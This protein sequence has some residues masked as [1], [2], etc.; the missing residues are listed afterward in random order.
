MVIGMLLMAAPAAY[1][2][3]QTSRTWV[4][5]VGNDSDPCSRTAPCK[6]FAGAISKTAI[7]GEINCLDPGGF[8]AVNITKSITIDCH[9][10]FAG[11]LSQ[12]FVAAISI[13]LVL[14]TTAD[15]LQTVRLRNLIV[16]GNGETTCGGVTCGTRFGTR[17]IDILS[18]AQVFLDDMLIYNFSAEGVRDRRTSPVGS[19]LHIRNSQIR[20]NG[21]TGIALVAN[22]GVNAIIDNSQMDFN[23][24]G[25]AVGANNNAMVFRS[26]IMGNQNGAEAD[27]NGVLSID[28]S[29][30]SSNVINGVQAAAGSFVRLSN[31]NIAFNSNGISGPTIS[32]GQNRIYP[33]VGTAPTPAGSG[34]TFF[35]QQ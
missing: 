19:K 10:I 7:N 8:G 20:D 35:G 1:A 23:A 3:A 5:G 2:Q 12:G 28:G 34:S 13:N 31:N 21:G 16:D 22:P 4:S 30:I 17:G 18:A 29:T 27:P 25:I 11:V 14:G 15:P 26:T 33:T 24:F 32:F 6:S 9:E